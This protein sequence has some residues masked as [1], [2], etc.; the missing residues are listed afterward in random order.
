M[1]VL[2]LERDE[3]KPAMLANINTMDQSKGTPKWPSKFHVEFLCW[4]AVLSHI[5]EYRK[6]TMSY[7]VKHK[8]DF[9][10]SHVYQNTVGNYLRNKKQ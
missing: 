8:N 1:N 9:A 6:M 10:S 3:R 2:H 7:L 4:S 5:K